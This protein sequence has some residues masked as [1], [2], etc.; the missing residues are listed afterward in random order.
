MQ[1][2]KEIL[3]ID[4]IT[5]I[6]IWLSNEYLASLLTFVS[7]PIFF[8]ILVISFIAEKIETSKISN[9]YWKLMIGLCLI[10]TIIF[11][12]FHFINKGEYTWLTEN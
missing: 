10:P 8:G 3:L 5:M 6:I 7:V 9:D 12:I 2:Y 11:I 1:Y 4:A